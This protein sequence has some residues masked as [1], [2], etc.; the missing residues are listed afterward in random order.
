MDDPYRDPELVP[1]YDIDNPDGEDRAFYRTLADELDAHSIIDLGCGTG[2]LTRSLATP[3]RTV[4]GVDPSQT[5]LDYARRQPG[6]DSV[7]WIH[8]DASALAPN[9]TTDLA[10]CTG[11]AIMH[12]APGELP[13]TL[14]S[15][16]RALRPGGTFSFESRNPARRA[17]ESWTPEATYHERDTP[18]GHLREWL[19]VIDVHE[20]R[21]TFDAHNV[22]PDGE[23]R[24]YTSVL[25]FR[26]AEELRRDLYAAGFTD[27]AYYGDWDG[28]PLDD[29]S[30]IAVFRATC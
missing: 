5:M 13:R 30:R 11:N 8:G 27:V 29:N 12:V 24:V 28:T 9:A 7:T 16:A 18:V 19:T 20:G 4:I 17:W 1:L 2:L 3:G 26:S 14:T 6:A 21:V 22:F 23:D 10:I 25:Y 15:I